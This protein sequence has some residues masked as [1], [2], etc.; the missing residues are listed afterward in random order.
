M[1]DRQIN[2]GA[3]IITVLLMLLLFHRRDNNHKNNLKNISEFY[4]WQKPSNGEP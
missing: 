4:K 2:Y 3:Y 1:E